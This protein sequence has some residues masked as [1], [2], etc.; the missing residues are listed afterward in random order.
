MAPSSRPP[1]GNGILQEIAKAGGARCLIGLSNEL[2]Y[3]V[4]KPD[5]KTSSE[6]PA[7]PVS[8]ERQLSVRIHG[9]SPC[10][11]GWPGKGGLFGREWGDNRDKSTFIR[12]AVILNDI[13]TDFFN[14]SFDNVLS[15][16]SIFLKDES[17]LRISSAH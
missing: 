16:L 2:I 13:F 14:S 17:W 7:G 4:N 3:N 9:S 5:S 10:P 12:E 15:A 8:Q 6:A 11:E 1:N